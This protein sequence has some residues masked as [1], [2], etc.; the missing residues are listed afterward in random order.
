MNAIEDEDAEAINDISVQSSSSKLLYDS[1]L[2]QN[3]AALSDD[4]QSPYP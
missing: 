3:Y 1:E 2:D 4:V